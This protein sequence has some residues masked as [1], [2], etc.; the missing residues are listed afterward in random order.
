MVRWYCEV[1]HPK[2]NW[3]GTLDINQYVAIYNFFWYMN[4]PHLADQLVQFFVVLYGVEWLPYGNR[5]GNIRILCMCWMI[6]IICDRAVKVIFLLGERKTYSNSN[7]TMTKL[8]QFFLYEKWGLL[9][10][11]RHCIDCTS[12][13]NCINSVQLRLLAKMI[14][15]KWVSC[16]M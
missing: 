16:K 3:I 2:V 1:I 7:K 6:I 12:I 15:N 11:R 4:K 8:K 9:K 10:M 5:V 13:V 14:V